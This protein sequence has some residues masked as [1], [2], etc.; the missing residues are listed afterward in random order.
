MHF[1][2]LSFHVLDAIDRISKRET[3]QC[4]I[5][6]LERIITCVDSVFEFRHCVCISFSKKNE[7]L[8]PFL[9]FPIFGK[10]IN[11]DFQFVF[12]QLVRCLSVC[13]CHC[14]CANVCAH[15]TCVDI[16][17]SNLF[18]LLIVHRAQTVVCRGIL[19]CLCVLAKK[20]PS[21]NDGLTQFI[22]NSSF[23][24]HADTLP[25]ILEL[26]L[27]VGKGPLEFVLNAASFLLTCGSVHD[28]EISCRAILCV[29]QQQC[30]DDHTKTV[31][32]SLSRENRHL[33]TIIRG[34]RKIATLVLKCRHATQCSSIF[35]PHVAA[36]VVSTPL[37][38]ADGCVNNIW[39]TAVCPQSSSRS[40]LQTV[41]CQRSETSP[42]HTNKVDPQ[43]KVSPMHLM[44]TQMADYTHMSQAYTQ[45]AQS[46][47][48]EKT[49]THA[50]TDMQT[51]CE[52]LVRNDPISVWKS[53]S[54]VD[55]LFKRLTDV[56]MCT[57]GTSRSV[58]IKWITS[59]APLDSVVERI[60]T[61][62][63]VKLK[64]CLYMI[65]TLET[66][67]SAKYLFGSYW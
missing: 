39:A 65:N 36:G 21:E 15:S 26:F 29:Y 38:T 51:F 34:N 46:A 19:K 49:E 14:V 58:A 17:S 67:E 24:Q 2:D 54:N 32:C 56:I 6:E 20:C 3:R 41:Q 27:C 45:T 63:M 50:P 30:C 1:G 62:S 18:Q 60:S 13:A 22:G 28:I 10:W 42:K 4:G 47:N 31:R 64:E 9:V 5:T 25:D 8:W 48:T 59:V 44:H 7:I 12:R 43:T 23:E 55:N 66:M 57:V 40:I 33:Q 37:V 61:Q 16:L 11:R 35:L 52:F 53:I